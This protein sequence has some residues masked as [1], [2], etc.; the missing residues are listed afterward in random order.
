MAEKEAEALSGEKAEALRVEK[1]DAP[2]GEE[3]QAPD[4]TDAPE[5]A[6]AQKKRAL[7]AYVGAFFDELMRAGV[8]DV[9]VSPGSR[10]TPLSMVAH[11]A[12]AR[13]GS[14]FNLYLDI[15]ERGAAFFALGIAKATGRAVCVICTSAW[16]QT[17][18]RHFS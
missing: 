3:G 18:S 11:E 9:V 13:F 1:G 10:S 16:A 6:A 4:A 15:D 14:A 2:V 12:H 17:L 8:R 7:G 5:L